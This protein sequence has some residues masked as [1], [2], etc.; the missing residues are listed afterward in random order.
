MVSLAGLEYAEL[1]RSLLA[2]VVSFAALY[3]I[4]S[5]M[6]TTSRLHELGWLAVTTVVWLAI[7][8]LVLRLSGSALPNQLMGRLSGKAA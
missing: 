1:G 5:L 2:A 3:G 4:R 7:S 8:M 6:H